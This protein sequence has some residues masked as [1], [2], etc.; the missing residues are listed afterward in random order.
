M[1]R[2]TNK[3][4]KGWVYLQS[5]GINE[6]VLKIQCHYNT[7]NQSINQSIKL[8]KSHMT[9]MLYLVSVYFLMSEI[10][11]NIQ[12]KVL[13]FSTIFCYTTRLLCKCKGHVITKNE[14]IPTK[15]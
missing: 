8:N 7:I 11:E 3:P 2:V 15:L 14:D 13:A 5:C 12:L 10:D 9:D 1:F 4:L 6:C